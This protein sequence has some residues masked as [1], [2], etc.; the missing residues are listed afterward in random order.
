M[1]TTEGNIRKMKAENKNP[2]QYSIVFSDQIIPINEHIGSP[3]S[4]KWSGII[5]CVKCGNKTQKS[6]FN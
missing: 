4:F 5:H 2:I 1:M 6:F 3:I